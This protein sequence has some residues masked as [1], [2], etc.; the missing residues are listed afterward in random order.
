MGGDV[1]LRPGAVA[2]AG[3][4]LPVEH[5]DGADGHLTPRAGI[6]GFGKRDLHEAICHDRHEFLLT[7]DA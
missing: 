7:P 5:E 3:E 2:G 1:V 6:A 4:D